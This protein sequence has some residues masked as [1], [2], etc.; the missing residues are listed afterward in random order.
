MDLQEPARPLWVGTNVVVR[1][2]IEISVLAGFIAAKNNAR[3]SA[4]VISWSDPVVTAI[5]WLLVLSSRLKSPARR[6]PS[7]ALRSG[8]GTPYHIRYLFASAAIPLHV[9]GPIQH[10]SAITRQEATGNEGDS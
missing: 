7:S 3:V 5:C 1:G 10:Q 9:G 2:G 6:V 4:A 8:T